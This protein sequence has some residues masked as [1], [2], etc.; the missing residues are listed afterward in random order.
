MLSTPC[1]SLSLTSTG[2]EAAVLWT[3]LDSDER[4]LSFRFLIQTL[5]LVSLPLEL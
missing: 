4:S 2:P 5:R 3:H 1:A